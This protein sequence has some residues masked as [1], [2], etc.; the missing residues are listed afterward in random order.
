[1]NINTGQP[2]PNF[3]MDSVELNG[4]K[5]Q[6][7]K[8]MITNYFMETMS[9]FGYITLFSAAFPVGPF[10][11]ILMSIIEIRMKLYSFLY[12]YRKPVAERTAGIGQWLSIWEMMSFLGVFTNYSLLFLKQSQQVNDVLFDG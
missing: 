10:L 9:D 12:V 11:F 1:M 5:Y 7:N 3:D 4:V 2:S 8:Q 6:T